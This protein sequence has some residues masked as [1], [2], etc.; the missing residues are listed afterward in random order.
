MPR[1]ILKNFVP[2]NHNLFLDW[3]SEDKEG[4]KFLPS[5]SKPDDWAKLIDQKKRFMFIAYINQ[6]PF[7]FLIL[8]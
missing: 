7:G 3:F 4:M 8:K 6:R 1:V 5:Y 2:E